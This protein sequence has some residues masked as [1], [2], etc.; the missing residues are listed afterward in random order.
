MK[1]SLFP[2]N[3]KAY[4]NAMVMLCE[5]GK[6]AVI[7]PTGTGKSFI[8]FKLCEEYPDATI[9][10][11][12]PSEYIFKTQLENLA[13]VTGGYVPENLVFYT[14][15]K[16]MNIS[17]EELSEIRPDYIILDEFH[18]AGAEFWGAGVQNLL[19]NYPD[20]PILGLSATN[21]RYLDNQ[22]DMA[23]ELFD[24]NVASEM[25]L[26]EAIVRGILNAPKYVLSVFSYQKAL[27]KYRERVRKAKNKA[28]RD[29]AEKYLEALRR[30]L[31]KADGLDV[32]FDKHIEQR[33]GKYIVF[34]AN[35][36]HLCQMTELAPSWFAR[37]DRDP[38]IYTAYSDDP[39]T[40][41]AFSDFKK[42]DSDHLKLLFCI[43][44]LNEGIHV[45]DV[46]GV[47]LLRPTVSPII[48]KQQIGRAL[49]AG[50]K[51]HA[52]IFDI[53]LNIENLY[54]IGAI[55]EEMQIAAAYYR[56]LGLD[57]E[58]VT[59]QF[60]VIDEVR[61]CIALF[62]RLNH[63]LT[64][65]WDLMY[66]A[67]RSYYEKNGSLDVHKRYVTEEGLTLGAWLN[68]QRMVHEGK[69]SGTL[70]DEQT[71]KL[72][73]IGMR[74]ESVRDIAWEK[75]YSAA[76][77][78]YEEHGHLLVNINDGVYHGVKLGAWIAQIRSYRKNEVQSAYLTP[79]R[80]R[81]LDQIGMVWSVPDYLFEKNFACC[82]AFY[83]Q[84]GHLNIPVNYVAEDGT[85]VGA[86]VHGLR[87]AS[88]N[89]KSNRAELTESQ[90]QRLDDLGFVWEGKYNVTW[91]KAYAA[92]AEYQKQH[93][94]LDIPVAHITEDGIRLGRWIR[95]QREAYH[96]SLPAERKA[97]LDLLGMTWDLPDPWKQKFD[98]VKRYYDEHG[99]VNIPANYVSDGVWIA[100]W[101]YEQ[102]ARLN[103]RPTGHVK[104]VKSLTDE[105]I[106]LLRSLGIRENVSRGDLA[107][108]EQYL[109]AKV[110][111]RE[112]GHLH[113]PK[114]YVGEN[115]KN[116]AGWLQ[117]QRDYRKKGKLSEEKIRLLDEI[118]MIWTVTSGKRGDPNA[119]VIL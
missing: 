84:N 77:A 48:Y 100:R 72:E 67:A 43:D 17:E 5:T 26:G 52:V 73:A 42:D 21:I 115:G 60:R 69:I 39:A 85:R 29:E 50:K 12:S 9:I 116:V 105:Q 22:R 78:Y 34:C 56:S 91:E 2:H 10:W 113:V 118:G 58:I 107:W 68:T 103:G 71:A 82:L 32:I 30:A 94:N 79:E 70:T 15:A 62:D 63:T 101:L 65:S 19:K 88:K 111:Y 16:L 114:V 38:H 97:K 35:Y 14:Y 25:S 40:S 53:V 44:M 74:W 24:G 47:I 7:H 83:R 106:Q 76:K 119:R 75:N 23:V 36:D 6:A 27:E 95:R 109:A 28:V 37:V 33:N 81:A 18:R 55:E 102:I 13:A 108:E 3:Q 87:T 86:W 45:D 11:L 61:D 4:E 90:K 1:I 89:S 98:L 49:S 46:C 54:S 112:N 92:A 41:R 110:F 57:D 96:T 31:E 8:G 99:D 80:I 93:G 66:E 20:V 117:T 51:N 59:E 64:A 104:S